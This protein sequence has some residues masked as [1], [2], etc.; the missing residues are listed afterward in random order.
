VGEGVCEGV[1]DIDT[2]GVTDGYGITESMFN[3]VYI[4]SSN[5]LSIIPP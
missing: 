4:L 5:I 2:N 3:P 1:G